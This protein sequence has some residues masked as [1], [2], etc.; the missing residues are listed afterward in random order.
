MSAFR[1]DIFTRWNVTRPAERTRTLIQTR[2][3][4]LALKRDLSVAEDVRREAKRLL[5]H[6]P[7]VEEILLHG[8]ILEEERF[9]LMIEPFLTSKAVD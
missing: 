3:F 5:R 7:S 1:K 4:F 9:D 2:D 8:R 6:Y